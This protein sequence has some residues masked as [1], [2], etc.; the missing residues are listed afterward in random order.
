MFIILH[1]LDGSPRGHWQP[2][3]ADALVAEGHKVHVPLFP[4]PNRPD[5]VEWILHLHDELREI[6][7]GSTVIA[8]SLGAYLWLH[9]ASRPGAIGADRVLLVAPPG[10]PEVKNSRRIVHGFQTPL[11]RDRVR[12]AARE[13]L[14]VGTHRDPYCK[15]GFVQT[16]AEPLRLPFIPL[17]DTAGHINL[18]SG[19][20]AWPFALDWAL[21]RVVR[22]DLELAGV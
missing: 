2:W 13:I 4:S 21:D 7:R 8:H 17:E 1:G 20:G 15:C 3:L 9:Y 10:I 5:L 11:S 18:D 22:D 16:Y 12:S 6:G 19:Y 14:L